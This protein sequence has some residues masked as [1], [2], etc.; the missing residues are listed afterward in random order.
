M[1]FYGFLGWKIVSSP[2]S[3]GGV[4]AGNKLRIVIAPQSTCDVNCKQPLE[5]RLVSLKFTKTETT[6][7]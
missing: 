1:E 4:N 6:F 3:G 5:F 2:E 7:S